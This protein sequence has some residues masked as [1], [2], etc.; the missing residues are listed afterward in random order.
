MENNVV[1]DKVV[2]TI[3]V[4]TYI[5]VYESGKVAK[6][7]VS[8]ELEMGE[9]VR[10]IEEKR[11]ILRSDMYGAFIEISMRRE[12]YKRFR[13]YRVDQVE[14]EFNGKKKVC[15]IRKS[16]RNRF[17]QCRWILNDLKIGDTILIKL[18]IESMK[19]KMEKLDEVE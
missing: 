12:I 14:V 4:H 19:V 17:C 15:G 6:N 11:V 5:D 8:E 18:D 10:V 2:K 1:E 13:D 3:I 9:E 7:V 16:R